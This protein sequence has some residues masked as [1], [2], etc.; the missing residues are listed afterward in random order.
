VNDRRQFCAIFLVAALFSLGCETE[1]T[2]PGP[3][4]VCVSVAGVWDLSEVRG[5]GTGIVCP[6]RNL[7]WTIYQS[8]CDI[9]IESQGWDHANGATGG[10]SGNHLYVE[11]SWLE[12]CYIYRESIDVM[13]DGD[14]MTGTYGLVRGQEVYPAYCP[15]LGICSASLNGVRR[16]P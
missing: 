13:V 3:S 10:I 1:S 6:D 11:W 9:T 14:T 7:T 5:T 12:G 2:D 4:P 8:G 15:G 16:A